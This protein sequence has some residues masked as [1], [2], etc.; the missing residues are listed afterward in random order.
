MT[1]PVSPQSTD[2]DIIRRLG[3]RNEAVQTQA[4]RQITFSGLNSVP[5]LL[6]AYAAA[7]ADLE[8]LRRR[9]WYVW[10]G[11]FAFLEILVGI[12]VQDMPN[13]ILT[14]LLLG[15]TAM[16]R[17]K[18]VDRARA[19]IERGMVT[20]L[21]HFDDV[22]LL[23][24]LIDLYQSN[25]ETELV[26]M[27][28][29]RLL[30]RLRSSDA[31]HVTMRHRECLYVELDRCNS[32][33]PHSIELVLSILKALEQIGDSPAIP[34]VRK[35]VGSA[36]DRRIQRAAKEC[37]PFLEAREE[38]ARAR[39]TLLRATSRPA[40]EELLRAVTSGSQGAEQL[41]RPSDGEDQG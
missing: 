5:G 11:G 1:E 15:A 29:I 27:P 37:L 13:A 16:V 25:S 22:L 38:H 34:H 2:I 31:T 17:S 8:E 33:V 6:A 20:A 23:G 40:H 4:A 39:G 12:L 24:I 41:L 7:R 18:V 14:I 36:K 35:L 3:S 21:W 30:R 19:T 26:V 9:S 32:I 10:L 28:L